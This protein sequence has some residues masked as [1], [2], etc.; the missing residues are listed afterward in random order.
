MADSKPVSVDEILIDWLKSHGYDGLYQED[1]ECACL[2]TD[3]CPCGEGAGDCRAGMLANCNA[4]TC[5]NGGGCNFHIS[6]RGH[7]DLMTEE[8]VK[9]FWEAHN[10]NADQADALNKTDKSE[11]VKNADHP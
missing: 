8:Q 2:V 6:E 3:L 1:G 7:K 4:E 10:A 9:A 11:A 5:A